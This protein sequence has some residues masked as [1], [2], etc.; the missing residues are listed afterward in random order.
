MWLLTI[1]SAVIT[2]GTYF[3]YDALT[4]F[5]SPITKNL[6]ISES[7]YGIIFSLNS[8]PNIILSLLSGLIIFKLGDRTS[9]MIFNS[10]ILISASVIA[11]IL[12]IDINTQLKYIT[13]IIAIFIL[14]ASSESLYI[15]QST[16]LANEVNKDKVSLSMVLSSTLTKITSL[17]AFLTVVPV[18][19]L[20]GSYIAGFWYSVI[21]I[22]ISYIFNLIYLFVPVKLN[23]NDIRYKWVWVDIRRL[24][25]GYYL[26]TYIFI[27]GYIP[28]YT[29]KAYANYLI[30]VRD[31]ISLEVSTWYFSIID[32]ILIITSPILAIILSKYIHLTKYLISASMILSI[33]GYWLVL[34][35]SIVSIIIL[36]IHSAIVSAAVWNYYPKV[37][38]NKYRE[39]GYSLQSSLVNLS[40]T[41]LYPLTGYIVE[42]SEGLIGLVILNS[43]LVLSSLIVNIY[44]WLYPNGSNRIHQ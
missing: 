13:I 3:F 17:I 8:I 9:S 29:F 11:L 19:N 34:W 7:Q 36:G 40:T 37:V 15:V 24:N 10:L 38:K 31:N 41:I 28:I 20:F 16:M 18:A 2:S 23:N 14:G 4:I 6:N 22:L 35:N 26:L 27:F 33:I 39:I 32:F 44:F 5:Q 1:L 43:G 42:N 25:T 21:I 30:S 12:T